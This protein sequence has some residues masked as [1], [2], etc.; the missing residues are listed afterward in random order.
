MIVRLEEACRWVEADRLQ[1]DV[2]EVGAP[3]RRDQQCLTRYLSPAVE[4]DRD[5]VTARLD[6]LCPALQPEL[7]ALAL[8]HLSQQ[9]AGLRFLHREDPVH[10]LDDRDLAPDAGE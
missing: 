3:P 7:A 6:R 5:G 9:G 1:A 8:Q 4:V 2:F 10:A